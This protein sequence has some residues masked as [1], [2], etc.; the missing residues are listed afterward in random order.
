MGTR[1]SSS[2]L[3][4]RWTPT[5]THIMGRRRKS[6]RSWRVCRCRP[7]PGGGDRLSAYAPIPCYLWVGAGAGAT[8]GLLLLLSLVSLALAL[9]L[10]ALCCFLSLCLLARNGSKT[11]LDAPCCWLLLAAAGCYMTAA[12]CSMLAT[13][14]H[15]ASDPIHTTKKPIVEQNCVW[16]QPLRPAPKRAGSRSR[17]T[18]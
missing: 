8:C 5:G 18:Y 7:P 4:R 15:L 14:S 12:G 17:G 6:A 9:A 2:P 3:V 11:G 13:G 10:S 16:G 1:T